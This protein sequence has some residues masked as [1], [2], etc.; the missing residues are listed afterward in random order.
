MLERDSLQLLVNQLWEDCENLTKFCHIW[1]VFGNW[2]RIVQVQRRSLHHQMS[3]AHTLD[4]KNRKLFIQ[5][6]IAFCL[7][8]LVIPVLIQ[9]P[10]I[11]G[12]DQAKTCNHK[13][14]WDA[15][16]CWKRA[17]HSTNAVHNHLSKLNFR[18]KKKT[19]RKVN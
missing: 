4:L 18:L 16:Q 19:K 11:M 14:R 1:L 17:G 5:P 8:N 10:E 9:P 6:L 12:S 2:I 15:N 13:C 3:H 7:S